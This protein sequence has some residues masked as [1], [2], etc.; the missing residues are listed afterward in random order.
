M[1]S[2]I[3]IDHWDKDIQ[4]MYIRE[5]SDGTADA[6]LRLSARGLTALIQMGFTTILK[7]SIK[8][9]TLRKE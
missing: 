5:N 2:E 1:I 6:S 3:D 7:E 4:V 8:N 9:D